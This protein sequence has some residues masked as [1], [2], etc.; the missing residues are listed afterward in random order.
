MKEGFRRAGDRMRE[1]REGAESRL[2]RARSRLNAMRERLSHG[3]EDLTEEGRRRV[4]AARERA[5]EARHQMARQWDR[6]SRAAMGAYDRQPLAAG[7]LAFAAG[8]AI[9][10]ALPRTR[11]ED[12]YFGD[13]SDRLMEEAERIFQEERA[14]LGRVAEATADE[15]KAVMR[16]KAEEAKEGVKSV[17]TQ[18]REAADR[19]AQKAKDE[20][21]KQ[22]LGKPGS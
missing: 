20:A 3:T 21:E 14:K 1:G 4:L 13:Q 12:E 10:A 15:A 16:E 8:A 7:A 19:V 9:A 5:V 22:N 6:Q 11:M 17:E 2:E 18:A